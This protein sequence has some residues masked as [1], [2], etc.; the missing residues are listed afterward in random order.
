MKGNYRST[1]EAMTAPPGPRR[2]PATKRFAPR[3]DQ[4]ALLAVVRAV[5]SYAAAHADP[6]TQPTL[7]TQVAYDAARADA[8]FADSK[9]AFRICMQLDASWS[10]V[11]ETAHLDGR[12]FIQTV[13]ALPVQERVLLTDAEVRDA[14]QAIA[15]RLEAK[16]SA[17]TSTTRSS[18]C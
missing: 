15:R 17:R 9:R 8:G 3:Y 11:L 18:R 14:L 16:R 6:R 5:S 13:A 4:L 10:K 1:F 12:H 2:C 7:I